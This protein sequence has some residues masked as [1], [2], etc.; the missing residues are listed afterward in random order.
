M[1]LQDDIDFTTLNWV[2]PELDQA[3]AQARQELES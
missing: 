3:L 1:R 2:K